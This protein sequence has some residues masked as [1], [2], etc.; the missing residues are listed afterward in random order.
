MGAGASDQGGLDLEYVRKNV[1]VSFMGK[2]LSTCIIDE[3]C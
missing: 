1:S 2:C 3:K